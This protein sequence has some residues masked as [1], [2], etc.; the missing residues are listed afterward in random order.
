MEF[1]DLVSKRVSQ[2]NRIQVRGG[3]RR[4]PLQGFIEARTKMISVRRLQPVLLRP[5]QSARAR[6][7]RQQRWKLAGIVSRIGIRQSSEPI[8]RERHFRGGHRR[9]RTSRRGAVS[10]KDQTAKLVEH[11]QRKYLA[12]E[13]RLRRIFLV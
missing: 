8:P 2:V 1:V 11:I 10:A 13:L 4:P 7:F 3:Q 6:A 5:A 12:G 9:E